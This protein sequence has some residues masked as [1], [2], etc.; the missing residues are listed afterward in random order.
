MRSRF[1][2]LHC[3]IRAIFEVLAKPDSRKVTPPKFLNQHIAID[4]HL[5]NVTRMI[6]SNF[7]I[8]N[9]FILTMVLL[10]QFLDPIPQILWF[11]MFLFILTF[12]FVFT[13][14]VINIY[15]LFGI[16]FGFL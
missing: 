10:V 9:S 6:A 16:N 2:Y 4:K 7:V 5:P 1:H 3:H 13:V 15:N 12:W 8:L 11:L 14:L